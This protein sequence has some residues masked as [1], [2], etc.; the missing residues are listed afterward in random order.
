MTETTRVHEGSAG[1]AAESPTQV[2]RGWKDVAKRVVAESKKDHLTLVSAGVA[3][4]FLIALIPAIAAVVS[5]YGFVANPEDVARQMGDLLEAAPSAV[6]DLVT[7]QAERVAATSDA[8]ASVGAIVSILLALWAASAGCQHL[9]EAVNLAYDEE[10]T[11]GFVKRRG[12]ALMMTVGAV[13]FLSLAIGAIAVVPALLSSAGLEGVA[14]TLISIARWPVI[15][16]V[17]I[18]ALAMLY[19]YAP[20][21]DEPRWSWA[22]PGAIVATVVWLV[23][24]IAFSIYVT[25]FG[26]YNETYGSLGAV[27]IVMLWLFITALSIVLGAEINAEAERQTARDTTKGPSQPMGSRD[28]YAADTVAGGHGEVRSEGAV[29]GSQAEESVP[30]RS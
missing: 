23:A 10:E 18:L 26:S 7:E 29:T 16:L 30:R 22:S 11:R 17:V 15:A 6:R 1:R 25:N 2:G 3:F 4:Y 20:D 21:R 13:V 27:I 14:S 28:A 8:A 12:L 24:S 9:I 19:R 5:I